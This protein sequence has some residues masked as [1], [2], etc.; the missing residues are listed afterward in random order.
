MSQNQ[1]PPDFNGFW[2][3]F[4]D[5]NHE[6][7]EIMGGRR[8][9]KVTDVIDDALRRHH[10]SFVYEVTEGPFGGELTFTP[11]GD[12]QVARVLDRFVAQA[13]SFDT[14]VVHSR[15]HRK[16]F[17]AAL[18]FVNALHGIDLT[19]LHFKVRKLGGQFHLLF[20]HPGLSALPE[21]QRAELI[22]VLADSLLD[23][24]E[25]LSP[26]WTAE[27]SRRISA[28]SRGESKLV[29]GDEVEARIRRA[30]E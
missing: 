18:A 5:H 11:E 15:R 27:I 19:G 14:W 12:P 23:T 6:I 25:A 26:E 20:I 13:P 1:P 2:Q 22:D 8:D 16:S 17:T 9:G 29:S 21:D 28:V 10:L 7:L 30:L 3:W 4:A 24:R